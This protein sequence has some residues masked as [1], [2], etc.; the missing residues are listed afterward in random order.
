MI[1]AI[2]LSG[3]ISFGMRS[4][5]RMIDTGRR[6]LRCRSALRHSG[7]RL[8]PTLSQP[9]GWHFARCVG[10]S[11]RLQF[12]ALVCLFPSQRRAGRRRTTG[13]PDYLL[14]IVVKLQL[15]HGHLSA[16]TRVQLDGRRM[17]FRRVEVFEALLLPLTARHS[18]L[19]KLIHDRRYAQL[20]RVRGLCG[21]SRRSGRPGRP[22]LQSRP[23]KG[24]AYRC[25]RPEVE[26][27]FRRCGRLDGRL[28]GDTDAY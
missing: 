5:R 8:P 19:A 15:V 17:N 1:S 22:R 25:T 14:A 4:S 18:K 13:S 12:C 20:P 21:A 23:E 11:R 16:P 27:I 2:S 26:K 3:T 7:G 24:R 6:S 9:S 10:T 28:D